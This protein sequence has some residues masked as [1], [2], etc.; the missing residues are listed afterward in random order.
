MLS[1]SDMKATGSSLNLINTP[2]RELV[3]SGPC[4]ICEFRDVPDAVKHNSYLVLRRVIDP[5]M[6]DVPG[7]ASLSMSSIGT[8]PA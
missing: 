7:P 1:I 2:I 8:I 6:R 3:R 4:N 5:M